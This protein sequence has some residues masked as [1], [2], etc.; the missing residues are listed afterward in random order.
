LICASSLSSVMIEGV[1]PESQ[2]EFGPDAFDHHALL[3]VR[4]NGKDG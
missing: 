4:V 1:P 3:P 2:V